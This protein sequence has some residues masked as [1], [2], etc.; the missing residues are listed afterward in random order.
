MDIHKERSVF[1]LV[2]FWNRVANI[3]KFSMQQ[4]QHLP[5]F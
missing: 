5:R 3:N 4:P 1:L 2:Q